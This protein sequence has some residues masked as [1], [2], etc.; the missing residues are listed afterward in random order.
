MKV[1][2]HWRNEETR[3]WKDL[4]CSHTGRIYPVKM[5]CY[6]KRSIDSAQSPLNTN[7]ILRGIRKCNP[8]IHTEAHESQNS[9]S[10]TKQKE[11]G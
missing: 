6:Q 4:P 5:P 11:Q 10:N 8:V 2:E 1:K 9:Q 7:D 3:R